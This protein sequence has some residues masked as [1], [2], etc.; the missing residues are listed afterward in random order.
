MPAPDSGKANVCRT[1]AERYSELKPN[2]IV[3]TLVF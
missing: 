2:I 1:E 3:A